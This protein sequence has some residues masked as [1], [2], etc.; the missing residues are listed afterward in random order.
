MSGQFV[1]VDLSRNS[2][3]AIEGLRNEGWVVGRSQNPPQF[4]PDSNIT[5]AEMAVLIVRA[6]KGVNF[7]PPP[8]TGSIPDV[9]Q[10]YWGAKW[11]EIAILLDLMDLYSNGNFYPRNPATRADVAV[12][13]W[14]AK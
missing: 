5:R 7:Q 3:D 9:N 1:D 12:L 6:E 11:I 10:N 14:L 2:Y 13:L 8:A 4:V